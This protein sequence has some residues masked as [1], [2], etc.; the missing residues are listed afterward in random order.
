MLNG[1]FERDFKGVWIPKEIWLDERLNALEKVIF[2]EINSLDNG[3][4]CFASNDY[5]AKFCQCSEWKVSNAVNK[6]IEYGYL[7]VLD[8]DG[9]R[10]ILQSCLVKNTNQP[11]EIH[12]A[13]FG[14]SQCSNIA[15]SKTSKIENK[16]NNIRKNNEGFL[17]PKK[18]SG[19]KQI[20]DLV[21]S[22]YHEKC[23]TLPKVQKITPKREKLILQAYS[24]YKQ[25]G[26]SKLFDKAGK[27][28]FLCGSTGWKA[29]MEWLL[30]EENCVKVIEGRYDNRS[31]KG[32]VKQN[33]WESGV[34]CERASKEEVKKAHEEALER[35]RNGKRGFF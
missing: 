16:E 19:K 12:K 24:S 33:A 28:D 14:N 21:V 22:M 9:R 11:C 10:R 26:I 3:S 32:S 34:S 6:L 35:E 7:K 17:I 31:S 18:D 30:K 1:D 2:T 4:G 23:P 13:D 15:I 8:F 25:E 20:F 27:S 5:L 29:D